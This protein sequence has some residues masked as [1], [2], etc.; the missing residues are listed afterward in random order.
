MG[1][2]IS[3]CIAMEHS[4]SEKSNLSSPSDYIC[5]YEVEE[6]SS[7]NHI[8]SPNLGYN[9]DLCIVIVIVM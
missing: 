3:C 1:A 2:A 7:D 8:T 4:I 6:S 9:L 5:A